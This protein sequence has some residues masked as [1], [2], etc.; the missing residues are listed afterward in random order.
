MDFEKR[1]FLLV[2]SA[3][4]KDAECMPILLAYE[5]GATFNKIFFPEKAAFSI[6]EDP[7]R[8][9]LSYQTPSFLSRVLPVRFEDCDI[10]TLRDD[11][12]TLWRFQHGLPS[13]EVLARGA[14]LPAPMDGKKKFSALTALYHAHKKKNPVSEEKWR[15]LLSD[16]ADRE[17]GFVRGLAQKVFRWR[18][19]SCF[20]PCAERSA[21]YPS[22]WARDKDILTLVFRTV[23]PWPE[24]Y[25]T[26]QEARITGKGNR[27]ELRL[28]LKPGRWEGHDVFAAVSRYPL[29][30]SAGRP[31]ASVYYP[32]IVDDVLDER[33][34]LSFAAAFLEAVFSAESI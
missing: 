15:R 10:R 32:M 21:L 1:D 12:G 8:R 9:W 17:R 3:G 14:D 31:I 5:D 19:E 23:A 20:T 2:E 11:A 30:L 16:N 13:K 27:L 4:Q 22:F 6:L 18:Q 7:Q 26:G 25:Y 24:V 33:A 28:I 34:V 29:D